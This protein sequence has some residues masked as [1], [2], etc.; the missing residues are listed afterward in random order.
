MTSAGSSVAATAKGFLR[1]A[2]VLLGIVAVVDADGL[3]GQDWAPAASLEAVDPATQQTLL[4]EIERTLGSDHRRITERRTA[5]IEGAMKATFM[6]MPK[7]EYGNLGHA[8]VRYTVHRYFVQRHAWFVKG[9]DPRGEAWNSSSPSEVLTNHLPLYV[10]GLF[11]KRLAGRGLNVHDMA[12]FAATLENLVHNETAHRLQDA[13]KVHRIPFDESVEVAE[14]DNVLDTF[15]VKYILG[16]NAL[17]TPGQAIQ[18]RAVILERYPSWPKTQKWVRKVRQSL[19][20]NRRLA[21]TFADVSSIIDEISDRYG[22]WQNQEC[23]DLKKD[24]LALGDRGSGCVRLADF[25]GSGSWQFRESPGYLRELGA[26]DA[27]DPKAPNV[28]VP[29]YLGGP[30]N[31]VATSKYYMVC[32]LNECEDLV[33]HLEREL[34]TPDATPAAIAAIVAV[35]PS[36]SVPDGR[37]LP[38]AL[39]ARLDQIATAH[40]GLVPLHGRLFAQ[41]M[42]HAYPRECPY[43]HISGTTKPQISED[44]EA[45]GRNPTATALEVRRFGMKSQLSQELRQEMPGSCSPWSDVEELPFAPRLSTSMSASEEDEDSGMSARFMSLL[46][47]I[48]TRVSILFTAKEVQRGEGPVVQV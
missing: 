11:E 13:Y 7:N 35:L 12:V 33:G 26:L 36:A 3:R 48:R 22:R 21:L 44:F 34:G 32:C 31:C 20:P 27:T 9:L 5:K 45:S 39:L 16:D 24:L 14:V 47:E 46:S 8:A 17:K 2:V 29:N 40:H 28:I 41:W 30:A 18:M 19:Y 25:Y 43:P 1:A 4:S 23:L 6:A 10:Q 15:M 42:H 38:A 37:I